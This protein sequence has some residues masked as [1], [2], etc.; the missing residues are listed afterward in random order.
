MLVRYRL[1][2]KDYLNYSA[3]TNTLQMA[4]G[5]NPEKRVFPK[6]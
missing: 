4:Y 2:A 5:T 6:Y 3:Y 1:R